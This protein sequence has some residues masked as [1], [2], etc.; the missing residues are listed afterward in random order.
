MRSTCASGRCG[1]RVWGAHGGRV[2]EGCDGVVLV[3]DLDRVGKLSRQ[4]HLPHGCAQEGPIHVRALASRR[5]ER[6]LTKR[7]SCSMNHGACTM[8]D[9]CCRYG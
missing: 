6:T 7:I 3:A 1:V 2:D 4:E 5:R 8:S 9:T